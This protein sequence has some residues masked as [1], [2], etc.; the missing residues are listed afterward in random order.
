VGRADRESKPSLR[1]RLDQGAEARD[2]RDQLQVILENV[3]DGILVQDQSGELVYANDA[4]A[5]LIGFP[6]ARVLLET[7]L[8]EVLRP[9]D[10]LDE[11]ERPIHPSEMPGRRALLGETV[12][13]MVIRFRRPGSQDERWTLVSAAPITDRMGHV[14]FAI[15]VLRDITETKLAEERL[16]FLAR[17]GE[18]LSSSLDYQTTLRRLAEL[19]APRLADWC[20]VDMRD[21]NGELRSVVVA[22]S[23]PAK[24]EWAREI[25]KRYP[26]NP[27]SPTGVGNVLRTGRS[28]LYAEIPPE[29]LEQAAQDEGH[30]RILK[31]VGL[32]S[33]MI[34][35]LAAGGQPVGTLTFVSSR[36]SRR[37]GTEDLALA[38]EVARRAGM[39][40]EN[41]RLHEAERRTRRA[42]ERAADRTSRLQAI[43]AALADALEAE[44]VASVVVNEGIAALEASG[45]A[46]WVLADGDRLEILY[47]T[48]Y[49]ESILEGFHRI[50]LDT[51]VPVAEAARR[52]QPVFVG[53]PEEL[54]ARYLDPPPGRSGSGSA[55]WAV[56]PL[57]VKGSVLGTVSFSFAKPRSFS[58]A[59]QGFMMALAQQAAQ[60]LERTKLYR[61]EREARARAEAVSLRLLQLESISEVA[62]THLDLRS[63]VNELLD[64]I[65]T[66]VSADRAV[67]LLRENDDLLVYAALGLEE[68]VARSVRV[69]IGQGIAG[70]IAAQAAPLVVEDVAAANPVSSY[71]RERARSLAG[72]P[73][74]HEGNVIGV[75]H[76][77]TDGRRRFT[78]DEVRL[79]QLVASRA[80]LA[81]NQSQ[82]YE[83]E[84]R[85]AETL[86]R[87]L[88]PDRLPEV[89]GLQIAARYLPGGQALEVGGDWFDAVTLPGGRVALAVGDVVGHGLRAAAV[90]G[91]VRNALRAYAVDGYPPSAILERLDQAVA[92]SESETIATALCLVLDPASGELVYSSA[93]HPPPLLLS[94]G[95]T[96]RYL[97]DARAVPLGAVESSVFP[98]AADFAPPGSTLVLYTDG[99]VEAR[100]LPID[101][102]MAR[103]AEAAARVGGGAEE[104]AEH[105]VRSLVDGGAPDDDVA[106]VVAR[107]DPP[108]PC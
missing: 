102:G 86:Q 35:P 56:L 21:D 38:E 12:I 1:D 53:S 72:V 34:V 41:A 40:I 71:L 93:G 7:P 49:E 44:A 91:Q 94:P 97:E 69:P 99:L 8:A 92:L 16:L 11:A 10:V 29:A 45:A 106:L 13:E 101:E 18:L 28:E 59:D 36:P 30:L 88:L 39:A 54:A 42:A 76:V 57:V 20:A 68:E 15:N 23:D 104:V 50:P 26:P 27:D 80:A 61:A 5:R 52:A 17:A 58:R 48:G 75:L 43:T 107:L 62:L 14:Q 24:M 74:V 77:S 81:I 83:R 98:E 33:V 96:A 47:P 85:I 31:E 9:F 103:L 3:A 90:M 89:D 65:R 108:V 84:H 87:S 51:A 55:A 37:F 6:S 95:E 100:D 2:W 67:L 78:A 79:L 32:S 22:H 4:A 66:L 73:L 19:V 25:R 46:V 105:V 70:R 63:L 60:A 64:R 82:V